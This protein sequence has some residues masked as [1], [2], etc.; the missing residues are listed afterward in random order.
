MDYKIQDTDGFQKVQMIVPPSCNIENECRLGRS[1]SCSGPGHRGGSIPFLTNQT[2]EIYRRLLGRGNQSTS[3]TWQDEHRGATET[4]T[5]FTETHNREGKPTETKYFPV[6]IDYNTT[7]EVERL[8]PRPCA[9]TSIKAT[10]CFCFVFLTTPV[11]AEVGDVSL[12]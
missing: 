11:A 3:H 7:I 5:D 9:S 1:I 12:E 4:Q 6:H 8:E 10:V 2:G